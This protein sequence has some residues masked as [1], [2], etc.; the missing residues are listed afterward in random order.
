[1]TVDALGSILFL[2]LNFPAKHNHSTISPHIMATKHTIKMPTPICLGM[3]ISMSSYCQSSDEK[4]MN[5]KLL[6]ASN[7]RR[8][9]LFFFFLIVNSLA[10]M[11]QMKF[12]SSTYLLWRYVIWLCGLCSADT[13]NLLYSKTLY[14]QI[15]VK[16]HKMQT[17]I[18]TW[19]DRKKK[20]CFNVFSMVAQN[21]ARV[22]F[23]CVRVWNLIRIDGPTGGLPSHM[24][25]SSHNN[26]NKN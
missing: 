3:T 22:G 4:K 15:H 10:N 1:M 2:R 25:A 26:N 18:G 23:G 6:S 20:T 9:L 13:V 7:Y 21:I 8:F 5:P 16:L 19:N 14:I 17:A 24:C 11:W 12:I